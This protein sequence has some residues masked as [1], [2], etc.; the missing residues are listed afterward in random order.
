MVAFLLQS[1]VARSCSEQGG[2]LLRIQDDD[3]DV[4]SAK[5]RTAF[6]RF[7]GLVNPDVVGVSWSG[8]Q[9]S[10]TCS[11]ITRKKACYFKFDFLGLVNPD[12]VCLV[13]TTLNSC[14]FIT[15]LNRQVT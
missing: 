1:M 4:L 9:P 3:P 6:R 2:T 8:W 13:G 5:I 14:S 15:T 7:P 12:A 11:F 10:N